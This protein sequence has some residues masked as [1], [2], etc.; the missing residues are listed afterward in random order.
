MW[1]KY[2]DSQRGWD[3]KLEDEWQKKKQE[4]KTSWDRAEEISRDSGY[5]FYDRHGNRHN[6][7][8]PQSVLE[9]ALELYF[10]AHRDEWAFLE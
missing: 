7:G 5:E 10:K 8:K 2:P 3:Q 1:I 9:E 4:V 6:S